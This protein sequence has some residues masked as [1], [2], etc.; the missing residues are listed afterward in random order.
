MAAVGTHRRPYRISS[1]PL[2]FTLRYVTF[3]ISLQSNSA[4]WSPHICSSHD[5]I[6]W[7]FIVSSKIGSEDWLCSFLW[8]EETDYT[9]SRGRNRC[10]PLISVGTVS[11][12][13]CPEM[14]SSD[15]CF[16][17]SFRS[18]SKEASMPCH[19]SVPFSRLGCLTLFSCRHCI[20][21]LFPS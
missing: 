4:S 19:L 13:R 17:S 3:L 14:R 9:R 7:H 2:K 18:S 6:R 10:G 1:R 21:L 12:W 20:F 16:L 8:V 5:T 15:D 11:L